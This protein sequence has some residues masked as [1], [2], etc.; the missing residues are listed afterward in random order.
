MT[1]KLEPA[2]RE[3]RGP[4]D[5]SEVGLLTPYLDFG[6]LRIRP[7]QDLA[8]RAEVEEV[9]KRIVALTLEISGM[10]LQLQAFAASK[11]AGL[12]SEALKSL[13]AAVV[14]Q[15]GQAEVVHGALGPELR[16]SAPVKMGQKTQ[17]RQS[18]FIGVDGPRWLLRGVLIGDEL[19]SETRYLGLIELFRDTVVHRGDVPFPPNELLP[20]TLPQSHEPSAAV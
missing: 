12:W 16:V 2:D 1:S 10:R 4:F 19:Y 17:L 9:S 18:R 20:L 5:S 6:S 15:G 13:E 8:I 14:A 11:S 3:Q 7:R